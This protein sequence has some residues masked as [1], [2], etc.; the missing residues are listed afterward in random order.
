MFVTMMCLISMASHAAEVV[1]L[2]VAVADG[3]ALTILD[4]NKITYK[5]RLSGIDAPEKSQAFGKQS[6]QSLTA[7]VL[8][9]TVVIEYNKSDKY[10]R[11]VGKVLFDDKDINLEQIK[12]GFAWHFKRYENEQEPEDRSAYANEE[13]AARRDKL[14][15]WSDIN[16]IPPWVFRKKGVIA[17]ESDEVGTHSIGP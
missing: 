12:R 6:K 14:G 16:P 8:N 3:D 17:V 2:V 13:N 1:G 4:T 10:Q 5:I 11:I 9:K 7:M 15:L